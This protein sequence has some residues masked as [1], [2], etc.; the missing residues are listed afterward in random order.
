MVIEESAL[1]I[2]FIFEKWQFK[3]DSECDKLI[4]HAHYSVLLILIG[5]ETIKNSLRLLPYFKNLY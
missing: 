3:R 2:V 1:K 4:G 5:A